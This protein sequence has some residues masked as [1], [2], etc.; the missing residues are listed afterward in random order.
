MRD[1]TF[2]TLIQSVRIDHP[3]RHPTVLVYGTKSRAKNFL[4]TSEAEGLMAIP[5]NNPNSFHKI[6]PTA[7]GVVILILIVEEIPKS[8]RSVLSDF[9]RRDDPLYVVRTY[10]KVSIHENNVAVVSTTYD[11]S[12]VAD[13]PSARR[14]AEIT[15][16]AL[17]IDALSHS[18]QYAEATE[19][20]AIKAHKG[21]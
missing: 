6:V 12:E 15:Q 19:A 10:T 14:I 11:W 4:E 7:C 18:P 17:E 16:N 1:D 20:S 3:N 2:N 13:T 5:I 9:C 21:R 8:I